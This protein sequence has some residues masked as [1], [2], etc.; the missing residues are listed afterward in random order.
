MNEAVVNSKDSTL[1]AY[2]KA[3][4]NENKLPLQP[5]DVRPLAHALT[6][7]QFCKSFIPQDYTWTRRK[8]KGN[9]RRRL[10]SAFLSVGDKFY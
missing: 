8:H 3:V 9:Q 4:N 10:Y 6:Y 5:D 7:V 2:F 1:M